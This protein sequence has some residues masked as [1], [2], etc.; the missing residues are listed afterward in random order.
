MSVEAISWALKLPIEQSSTKFVLVILANCANGDGDWL[1]WPSAQYIVD[2][3]SQDLKTVKNNLARLRDLGYIEDSGERR[4][5]TKQVVVYR[6]HRTPLVVSPEPNKSENGS[7]TNRPVFPAKGTRFSHETGPKTDHGT[8][9]EPSLEPSLSTT[10][11]GK[12]CILMRETG[13][14]QTNPSHPKLLEAIAAGVTPEELRDVAQEF[15]GKP[16]IYVVATAHRR[17]IE[18]AANGQNGSGRDAGGISPSN[19]LERRRGESVSAWV[20]RSN[21]FHDEREDAQ[22]GR[23][24]PAADLGAD[25]GDLRNEVGF[26]NGSNPAR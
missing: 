20:E 15:P 12:A 3:T 6:I 11:A 17:K 7:V 21:R 5:R 22:A 14:I 13:L 9:R 19:P 4:G 18:G 1:A 26:R 2:A 10:L 23:S 8:V 24:L 25:G 16:M